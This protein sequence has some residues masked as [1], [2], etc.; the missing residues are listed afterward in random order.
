MKSRNV[1]IVFLVAFLLQPIFANLI[2]LF[3]DN[4]N[5]IL[6]LTVITTVV[7]NDNYTGI[8]CGVIFTFLNDFFFGIYLGP[9]ALSITV[10]IIVLLIVRHFV[11]VENIFISIMAMVTS[12]WLYNSVYWLVYFFIGSQYTYLTAIKT[13]PWQLLFNC[14]VGVIVY[15]VVIKK[16]TKHRR[17]RYFR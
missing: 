15:L 7:V 5:F 4:A 10:V 3:G 2:P 12:T 16:I 8:M 13:L 1:F 9:G 14:V 17:D 11:N 6:C